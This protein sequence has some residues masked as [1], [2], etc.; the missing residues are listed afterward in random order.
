[1]STSI[2]EG[3]LLCPYS[4]ETQLCQKDNQFLLRRSTLI[5]MLYR[6]D[7]GGWCQPTLWP[8]LPGPW[9]SLR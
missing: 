1:M 7:E 6:M 8:N 5:N 4:R 9:G 2:F 3:L